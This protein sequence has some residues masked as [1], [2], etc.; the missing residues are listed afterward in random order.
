ME[1]FLL[2]KTSLC[3]MYGEDI[4]WQQKDLNNIKFTINSSLFVPEEN[5][6]HVSSS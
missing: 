4:T 3:F 1:M 6:V 2:Y 5:K